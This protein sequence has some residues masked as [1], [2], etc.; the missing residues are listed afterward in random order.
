MPLGL[1]GKKVGMTRV[2]DAEAG[3][4]IPV[5]VID[6]AGNAFLQTKTTEKDGY[7]AVQIGYG[8]QKE[9]RVNQPALGH[10]KKHGS[11]PKRVIREFRFAEGEEAPAPLAAE[12]LSA[13][14]E[15]FPEQHQDFMALAADA[16]APGASISDDGRDQLFEPYLREEFEYYRNV[17]YGIVLVAI[18]VI[19]ATSMGVGLGYCDDGMAGEDCRAA[20]MGSGVPVA[21]GV[22]I[23]GGTFITTYGMKLDKL[24]EL[25]GKT[26]DAA[27][28]AAL[29][30]LLAP[31]LDARGRPGGV[32]AGIRF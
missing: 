29:V 10:V 3:S 2:F 15:T 4:M 20:A 1:L 19:L 31:L 28:K 14:R 11:G 8:E 7:D 24:D 17:G 26:D 25:L 18:P 13:L 5:T 30:P 16:I 6:V 21:V 12:V 32:T 23:L 27:K 9:Q 22:A